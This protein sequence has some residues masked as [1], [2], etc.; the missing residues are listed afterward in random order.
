[1]IAAPRRG[2]ALGQ[3]ANPLSE[4][5]L[6]DLTGRGFGQFLKNDALWPLEAR[7]LPARVLNQIGLA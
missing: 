3:V 6:S 7:E 2:S 4:Q 1:M 5:I